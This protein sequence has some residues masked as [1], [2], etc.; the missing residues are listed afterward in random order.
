MAAD[1]ETVGWLRELVEQ[2]AEL[3]A[4]LMRAVHVDAAAYNATAAEVLRGRLATMRWLWVPDAGTVHGERRFPTARVVPGSFFFAKDV[5]WQDPAQL[6]D[7]RDA[8]LSE[9]VRTLAIR[10]SGL[11]VLHGYY[12]AFGALEAPLVA[13]GV[14][15]QPQSSTETS[16]ERRR[17]SRETEAG[18]RAA[19]ARTHTTH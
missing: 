13:C 19:Q 5:A 15:A 1:S 14:A 18:E 9:T 6:I 12:E 4:W 10:S 2:M 3:Y 11:R 8:L 17:R 16:S 7:S